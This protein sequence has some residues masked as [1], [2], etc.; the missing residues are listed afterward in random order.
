MGKNDLV[1]IEAGD[2]VPLDADVIEGIAMVD[3]S[4][5]T[6]ESDRPAPG[7]ARA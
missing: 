2:I 7:V 3:E 6:G 1:L 4:L 5:V